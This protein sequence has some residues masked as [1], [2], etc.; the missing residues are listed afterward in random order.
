GSQKNFDKFMATIGGEEGQPPAPLPN[1]NEFKVMIAKA[2]LFKK[3]HGLVRPMFPAFQANVAAYLVA[4]TANRVGQRM[5][6]GRIWLQQDIS[7]TLRSQLQAW[8]AEVNAVLHR[9]AAGRMVS[10][11]AKRPECWAA[12]L[13]ADYSKP[14]DDI[15]ELRR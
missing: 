6:L 4:L 9:S 3:A 12:V 8:A 2:I 1:V 10:E 14:S 5:D 15:P 13:A 11:W 7:A